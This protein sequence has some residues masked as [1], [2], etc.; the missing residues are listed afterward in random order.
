MLHTI[1][2]YE[3]IAA[4][5]TSQRDAITRPQCANARRGGARTPARKARPRR[6]ASSHTPITHRATHDTLLSRL[7]HLRHTTIM[8]APLS[9]PRP[10]R[11]R[12]VSPS[13]PVI[14]HPLRRH[15]E[16]TWRREA[17]AR[18]A[19]RSSTASGLGPAASAGRLLRLIAAHLT[20]PCRLHT[21]LAGLVIQRYAPDNTHHAGCRSA[22]S[23]CSPNERGPSEASG[24]GIRSSHTARGC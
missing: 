22:R 20:P 5:H 4:D 9:A 18:H 6:N 17:R 7:P 16:A 1:R 19:V 12:A 10:V 15:R 14:K 21:D 11:V 8:N 2:P 13:S 24:D 3:I 23:T